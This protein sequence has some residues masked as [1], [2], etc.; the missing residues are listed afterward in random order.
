[1]VTAVVLFLFYFSS[2]LSW[3]SNSEWNWGAFIFFS[4]F[5]WLILSFGIVRENQIGARSLFGRFI[6]NVSS[7]PVLVPF[8]FYRLLVEKKTAVQVEVPDEPENVW[9]GDDDKKPDDK[10]PPIRITHGDRETA[11]YFSENPNLNNLE[12]E[13]SVPFLQLPPE[14]QERYKKDP[15]HG[16]LVS[17]VNA[18]VRFRINDLMAFKS[19][20]KS[21]R[22][23]RRQIRDTVTVA[24]QD[25]LA[26]ITPAHANE[27]KLLISL[28]VRRRVEELCGE[29]AKTGELPDAREARA[30]GIS[31][32]DVD[33]ILF[34]WR[35]RVNI[36]I[37][38]AGAA[39]FN[40]QTTITNA[41]AKKREREL[42]GAGEA[43]AERLLGRSRADA[44]KMVAAEISA[45]PN[46]ELVARLR[47]MEAVAE[48][49]QLY[50]VPSEG[51]T[52]AGITIA[53]VLNKGRTGGGISP[54]PVPPVATPQAP[55]TPPPPP[56]QRGRR[57]P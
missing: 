36:S 8:P 30:W 42:I 20:T 32:E 9:K 47:T 15:L 10:V 18:L 21:L 40:A 16:R 4:S 27:K 5:V 23:A 39:G 46:G 22:D 28:M 37:A 29:V 45:S 54:T 38:D 52:G 7:G 24:L 19:N 14:V 44:L 49:S 51:I 3:N 57:K 25:I 31:V 11:K 13:P 1:M 2:F 56:Q 34:D 53:E 26:G 41:G 17:E 50:V 6:D 12:N 55:Q 33:I 43:E 35:Q 48:K